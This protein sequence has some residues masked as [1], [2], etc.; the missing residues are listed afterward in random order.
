MSLTTAR[1]QMHELISEVTPWTDETDRDDDFPESGVVTGWVLVA[2]WQGTDGHRW[3][4]K[5][6]GD[7]TGAKGLPAW[8]ERGLANEVA[9][10]WPDSDSDE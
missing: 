5:L 7:A 8:T 4:S 9:Q 3:L 1:E 6:S 2:E 10:H